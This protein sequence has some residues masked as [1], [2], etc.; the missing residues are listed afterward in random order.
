MMPKMLL[1][2]ACGGAIG[3]CGRFLLTTWLFVPG[4][5]PWPTLLINVLGSFGIGVVWGLGLQQEW[6][7]SWGRYLL[8]VG[9]LGGFTTFSAFSL[10]TIAL[11]ETGRVAAGLAYVFLSV[12]VCIAAAWLG[13]LLSAD[14]L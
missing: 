1:L 8:V 13:Q 5:L 11:L 10:E 12:T 2:V 9:V 3:A 4:Q 7:E 6:F 14:Y